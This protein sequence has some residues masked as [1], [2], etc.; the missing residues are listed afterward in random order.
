LSGYTPWSEIK[1]KK[2]QPTLDQIVKNYH[3]Y[4]DEEVKRRVESIVDGEFTQLERALAHIIKELQ[5]QLEAQAEERE[6]G[7]ARPIGWEAF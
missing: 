4:E 6:S 3:F 1:H 5:N 7:L 2:D